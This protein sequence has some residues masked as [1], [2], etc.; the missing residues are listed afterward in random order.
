VESKDL[1]CAPGLSLVAL[2]LVRKEVKSIMRY[3]DYHIRQVFDKIKSWQSFQSLVESYLPSE[4]DLEC[5]QEE[6]NNRDTT[7]KELKEA[8]KTVEA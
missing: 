1:A 5:I 7:I 3:K 6:I 8:A 4:Y 2:G